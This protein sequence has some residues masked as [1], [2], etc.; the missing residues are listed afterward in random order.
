MFRMKNVLRALAIAA[1][2]FWLQV[3]SASA[4][5]DQARYPSSPIKLVVP[6]TAGGGTDTIARAVAQVLSQELGQPVIVENRPG[7]GATLGTNYVVRAQPD[8]YTLLMG[9][10]GPIAIT[11]SLDP[12]LAYE[13]ARDLTPIAAVN[14]M[15]FMI[16]ANKDFP[17]NNVAQLVALAKAQPGKINFAS[18]GTATTSHLVNEM[19]KSYGRVE[20]THIPYKGVAQAMNDVT[21]GIVQFMAGDL[22]TLL[23]V[24]KSGRLKAL[25]TTGATRS[26]LAP[27]VPTVAEGGLEG[28]EATG[29]FGLFA[30]AGTPPEIVDKLADAVAKAQK[31]PDVQARITALGGEPLKLRGKAFGDY[32]A[33][34]RARWKRVI[35]DHKLSLAN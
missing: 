7:A 10:N 31:T 33:K 21:G 32:V 22:N 24:I 15:P 23:P 12:K 6:L 4:G 25:A 18:S 17:A 1:M 35:D 9:S 30:P 2:P 14:A 27:D 16:A 28:F 5:A 13:P 34:E 11:P 26:P 29:W 3:A 19:L 20:M 8:G